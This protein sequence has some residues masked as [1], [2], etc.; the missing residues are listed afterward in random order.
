MKN[1]FF[2]FDGVIVDSN[3]IKKECY[4]EI[5]PEYP[6]EIVEKCLNSKD[7]RYGNIRRILKELRNNDKELEEYVIRYAISTE[8]R[9][10]LAPEIPGAI[11]S[12]EKLRNKF[13]LYI[14]TATNQK[15]IDRVVKERRL[16]KY[17]RGVYGMNGENNSKIEIVKKL[18]EDKIITNQKGIFVGDGIADKEC[19][20]YFGFTFIG[21][22]NNT[23]NFNQDSNVKYKLNDLIKLP[24]I[25]YKIENINA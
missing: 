9:T 23:N 12:L 18:I 16:G 8:D 11:S 4:F 3:P 25:I 22:I 17:F 24:E 2:D 7:N 1:I 15:S 14:I 19:A 20:N 10:I 5:F 13:Q 6:R 21:I